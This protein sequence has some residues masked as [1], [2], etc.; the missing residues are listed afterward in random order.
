MFEILETSLVSFCGKVGFG[1]FIHIQNLSVKRGSWVATFKV[2][3]VI[4]YELLCVG[5]I[6][7]A[8]QMCQVFFLG[9]LDKC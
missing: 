8:N 1:T 6:L 3:I 7:L 4:E 9:V 5:G 2:F